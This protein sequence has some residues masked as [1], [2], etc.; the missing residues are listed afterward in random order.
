[1]RTIRTPEKR[2][3][4][5]EDLANHGNVT[6]A[7][8]TIGVGRVAIY[9][10]RNED[11]EFMADWE[12]ALELGTDA[13]E[14]EAVR[15]GRDGVLRPVYQGGAEV[16]AVREYSDTLL[17]FMLKARRPDKFKDRVQSDVTVT[18]AFTDVLKQADEIRRSR[19][20]AG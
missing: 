17:I 5:L 8:E 13:L 19:G 18:A 10:W 6:Q 15:R 9:K 14:D 7:C 2:A 4:F 16:G 1:M 12:A 3:A 11:P 20:T